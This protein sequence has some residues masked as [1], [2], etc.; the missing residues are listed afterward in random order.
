MATMKDIA[1]RAGVSRTTVG[2]V[3]AN[4]TDIRISE[5]T[6]RRVLSVADELRFRPNHSARAMQSGRFGMVSLLLS[7]IRS[8]SILPPRL[9]DGIHEALA[10]RD[11]HLVVTKLPDE[12]L[13]SSGFVPKILRESLSDG[14]LVNYNSEVPPAL[15]NLIGEHEIPAVWLNVKRATDAVHPDDYGMGHEAGRRLWDA[16]HRRVAFVDYGLTAHYSSED[17]R[18][19]LQSFWAERG[20]AHAFTCFY[21]T[22]HVSHEERVAECIRWLREA[23]PRPTAAL[24][25]SHHMIP[26]VMVAA[27][28]LGLRVP[29]DL[30][31]MVVDQSHTFQFGLRFDTF[32]LPE[33]EMGEAAVEMLLARIENPSVALPSRSFP[34]QYEAGQTVVTAPSLP[35]LG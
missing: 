30:S 23:N 25:Y 31:L 29:E 7:T 21:A 4:R 3:L 33:F 27:Q 26:F 9:L 28:S 35:P 14:L 2:F 11:L 22:H 12:K 10:A 18:D 24:L 16:G 17:R 19:G 20:L 6:R 13:A 34:A 5:A 1:E 15:E 8:R 32:V